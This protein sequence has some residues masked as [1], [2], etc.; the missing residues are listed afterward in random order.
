VNLL[1]CSSATARLR[2]FRILSNCAAFYR[3][4]DRT[5]TPNVSS[6]GVRQRVLSPPPTSPEVP[7]H[8]LRRIAKQLREGAA[9]VP[10]VSQ[11]ITGSR[12]SRRITG[13]IVC[14]AAVAH[15]RYSRDAGTLAK[16]RTHLLPVLEDA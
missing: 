8:L 6:A 11:H 3:S 9:P 7:K 5:Q 12:T 16:K 14:A 1:I 15:L 10:N 4:A 13:S 2:L